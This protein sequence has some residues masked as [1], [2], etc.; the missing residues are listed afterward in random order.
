MNNQI[1]ICPLYLQNA[2]G[3]GTHPTSLQHACSDLRLP[4]GILLNGLKAFMRIGSCSFPFQLAGYMFMWQPRWCVPNGNYGIHGGGIWPGMIM[5]QGFLW[6][7]WGWCPS[8]WWRWQLSNLQWYEWQPFRKP[9][10]QNSSSSLWTSWVLVIGEERWGS[11]QVW[12]RITK[13]GRFWPKGW[14]GNPW[15]LS[16]NRHPQAQVRNMQN[17]NYATSRTKKQRVIPFVGKRNLWKRR[18]RLLM[19]T[20]R[21]DSRWHRVWPG[22]R[23]SMSRQ[24]RSRERRAGLTW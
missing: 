24:R 9:I 14:P 7:L 17:L 3:V 12:G 11:T 6:S 15:E 5:L 20:N 8:T 13:V 21:R 18:E 1:P 23:V 2:Q 16:Q 19:A 22:L 4:L 10:H